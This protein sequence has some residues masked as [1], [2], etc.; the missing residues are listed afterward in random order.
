MKPS[1]QDNGKQL[2]FDFDF[3]I[4]DAVTVAEERF[5]TVTHKPTGQVMEFDNRT[6]LWGDWRKREGGWIGLK[7]KV[8]GNDYY[9]AEDFD[10]VDGHRPRP[11][12][13]K[14]KKIGEDEE[15]NPVFEPDTFLSPLEGAKKIVDAKIAAICESL[16][17]YNYFGFTGEG[18]VFRHQKATLLPY[19]GNR[20]DMLKP[21]LVDE[22]KRYVCEHHNAKLVTGIETDDAY[23]MAV[24]AG[25]KKWK[26][27]KKEAD[28]IIGVAIDKDSKQTDGWQ[29]NPDKDTA[30]RLIEGFGSLWLDEKGKVDGKGRMWLYFQMLCGDATDNYK[31]N[32]HS[33]VKYAEKGAYNDLKDCKTDKEAWQ[34]MYNV[35]KRLYPEK[36]TVTT[37]RGEIEIDAVYVMQEMATLAMMQRWPDDKIDVRAVMGKLGVEYE[38]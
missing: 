15:G 23:T 38:A 29:F 37:F 12:R 26:T 25:Y 35:F 18:E 22:I 9:K 7:N 1:T 17:C 5:I 2:C 34:A 33:V 27:T 11:F 30:P 32:S 31:P 19:K 4:F 20:E 10:V 8:S 14:G 3:I 28:K 13:V 24:I 16:G 36:K 6:A 21:F